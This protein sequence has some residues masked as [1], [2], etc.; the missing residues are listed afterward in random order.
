[1]NYEINNLH[2]YNYPYLV[3]KKIDHWSIW[4]KEELLQN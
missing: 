3:Y 2:L 4:G 1:M